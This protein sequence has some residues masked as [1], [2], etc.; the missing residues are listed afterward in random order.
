MA[1]SC[2]DM[3]Q[4]TPSHQAIKWALIGRSQVSYPGKRLGRLGIL[5]PRHCARIVRSHNTLIDYNLI[6]ARPGPGRDLVPC[7]VHVSEISDQ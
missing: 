7:V 5:D 6:R 3:N 4:G 2:L 1:T